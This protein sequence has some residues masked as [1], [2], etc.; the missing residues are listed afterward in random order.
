MGLSLE[1]CIIRVRDLDTRKMV[2]E[3]FGEVQNIVLDENGK[4]KI[5]ITNYEVA[6]YIPGTSSILNVHYA[7]NRVHRAS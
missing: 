2:V 4:D 1:H 7:W 3:L 6:G 5:I